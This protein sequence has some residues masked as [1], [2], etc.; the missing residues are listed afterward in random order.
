MRRCVQVLLLIFVFVK[1]ASGR[2]E[3]SPDILQLEPEPATSTRLH[4]H[5]TGAFTGVARDLEAV[6]QE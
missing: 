4:E 6:E 2:A 1:G 3:S 5:E